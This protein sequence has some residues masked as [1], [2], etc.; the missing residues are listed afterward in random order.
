MFVLPDREVCLS[1]GSHDQR[2]HEIQYHDTESK[3][4]LPRSTVATKAT[5]VTEAIDATDASKACRALT[6]GPKDPCGSSWSV[7]IKEPGRQVEK[8]VL[9]IHEVSV[10]HPTPAAAAGSTG[11]ISQDQGYRVI[12]V[13]RA[14]RRP[15]HSPA[16]VADDCRPEAARTRKRD[17]KFHRM[18]LND[19][20]LG[21]TKGPPLSRGEMEEAPTGSKEK[22]SGL[23]Y[24]PASETAD[25]RPPTADIGRYTDV[26]VTGKQDTEVHLMIPYDS[27]LGEMEEDSLDEATASMSAR[28]T[29]AAITMRQGTKG[30]RRDRGGLQTPLTAP[31]HRRRQAPR[32]V[33]PE[34][35]GS[36]F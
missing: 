21:K 1:H 6:R 5:R 13:K 14:I 4:T 33:V 8:K 16:T 9:L 28:G 18:T 23:H 7:E 36:K 24:G 35:Q 34:L 31:D 22:S 27:T 32:S 3:A 15:D 29:T 26:S 17:T 12:I 20:I 19:N 10:D 2:W 11:V 25:S 30:S